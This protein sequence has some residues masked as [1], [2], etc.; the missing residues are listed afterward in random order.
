MQILEIR[1][2]NAGKISEY[3]E[4]RNCR[5]KLDVKSKGGSVSDMRYFERTDDPRRMMYGHCRNYRSTDEVCETLAK[6]NRDR[7]HPVQGETRLYI[8]L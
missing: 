5:L 1:D 3:V 2:R 8:P 6:K 4:C 7:F